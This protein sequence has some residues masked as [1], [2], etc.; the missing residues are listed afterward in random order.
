MANPL[1]SQYVDKIVGV[2]YF[3]RVVREPTTPV[4]IEAVVL[5]RIEKTVLSKTYADL[6]EG[7]EYYAAH[8]VAYDRTSATPHPRDPEFNDLDL[9]EQQ[10]RFRAFQA[11]FSGTPQEYYGLAALLAIVEAYDQRRATVGTVIQSGIKREA[12][13]PEARA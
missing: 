9:P 13:M 12:L 1:E 6:C 4:D 5:D 11:Q 10:R 3:F 7:R 8:S 2:T